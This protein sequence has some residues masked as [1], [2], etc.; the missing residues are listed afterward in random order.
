V[1]RIRNATTGEIVAVNVTKASGWYERMV[2]LIPRKRVDPSEGVWF[3]D[4][5]IIHTIGMHTRIDVI[6]LDKEQRVLRTVCAVAQNRIA[7]GCY[8]AQSVIEL[9]SGTLDQCDVLLGDRLELEH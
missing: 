8:G 9:G 4:C 3:E 1:P 2:G 5:S 7:L 6:F